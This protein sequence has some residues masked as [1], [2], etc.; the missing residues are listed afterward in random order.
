[1]A[2]SSSAAITDA[3]APNESTGVLQRT[4]IP[5]DDQIRTDNQT[6]TD[7]NSTLLLQLLGFTTMS[8]S[9]RKET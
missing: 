9:E 8:E 2:Q 5:T 1:M 6:R 7:E 4:N 3:I